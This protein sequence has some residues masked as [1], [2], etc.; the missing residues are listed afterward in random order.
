MVDATD[1]GGH[2]VTGMQDKDVYA[3][4]LRGVRR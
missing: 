3:G 4:G 1:T 2:A